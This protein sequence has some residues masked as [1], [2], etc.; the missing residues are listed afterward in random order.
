MAEP[1]TDAAAIRIALFGQPRV[2]SNDGTHEYLLPRKTL[3]VLAY[4]IL[5]R[6]RAP[7]R[8]TIAFAL[9]PDDDEETAR[10]ALRRNLSYLLQ[11]LPDGRRF[12]D[13][14][15]ERIAWKLDA[16]AHVDV[17]AFEQA[18]GEGRDADAIAEYAGGLLPTI[19]DEWTTPDRERLRDA[20]HNALSRTIAL[21]RSRRN[22]DAATATARRLLDDDPWREDIVRQLMAVRYE[23][24]DRAGALSAFERFAALLRSEM[25]TEPMPETFALRDTVLR[26][27]R[28]PT[29]EPPR[30][31]RA[32]PAA[33][34]PGLPFVGRDAAMKRAHAAWQTAADGRAGLLFVSG[35]AGVGKS[36]FTTELVRL[37]ER[38]GGF[39]AR[40]YTSAGGEQQPYEAFIE[41]LHGT[42]SLLEQQAG[43]VL[44]DD[45]AARL[46][47][48][49]SVRHRL[50]ELSRARP[51]VLVLEDL[52][53]A[54]ASTIEL[55]DFVA[56]RLERTPVLIVATARS[57]ELARAHPLRPVRRELLRHGPAT[58][59]ALD[60]LGID[61]ATRAARAA[62]PETVDE[63][64]LQRVISWVD[65]V[66]LLLAE[67]VRDLAAGRTSTA[68][69]MTTLVAE[70][71]ER[72]SSSAE[73]A[74]IFGALL[75][76]RFDLGTLVAAT[77]WRDDQ[78]LD[79]L[80]E[81]IE[82]GFVRAAPH[83]PDLAF[84]FTHDLVRVA[85]MARISESDL[86]RTH[87]LIARAIRA[88]DPESG[89]RARQIARHFAAAG[90]PVRAAEH[91][92]NA[93]R[94]ALHVFANEDARE[95]AAAA[96]ALCDENE[97]AQRA[98]RY[99]L[100]DLREQSLARIGAT[101]QRRADAELLVTLAAG[102]EE[103][104][105]ALG[106]L[107]EAHATDAAGRREA[108][109]RLAAF[110]GTS[111]LAARTHAAAAARHAYLEGEYA[112][113]REAALRA[114]EAFELAG[115]PRAALK[116]RFVGITCLTRIGSFTQ[117][118]AEVE[119]LRPIV[120]ASDDD[121]LR[122]EFHLIAS[123]ALGETRRE[124]ALEDAR[125]SLALALRIGDRYGE[126][127]ARHNVAVIAGKLR[128]Y[129]EALDGHER[130]LAAYRDVGDAP[131]V[132]DTLLNIAGVRIWCGDY[133]RPQQL[134]DEVGVEEEATPWLALRCQ[135][136]RGALAERTERTADAER[137]LIDAH[138]R[139]E[140]LGTALYRARSEFELAK[141]LASHGRPDAAAGYVRSALETY[142]TMG[143]PDLEIEALALGAR[144]LAS[145]GDASGA[146]ER[147]ERAAARCKEKRLQSYSEIAWNLAA[148]Y[149]L[150]G[151]E[152]AA[153]AYARDAAAAAVDDALRMPADLAETYLQL[154]W[155]QQT[156]AYLSGRAVPLRFE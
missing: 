101:E 76:E 34:E 87:G 104:A 96:L 149:A 74:L 59:I 54:G 128:L 22:Y 42:P 67:A 50:S 103:T 37:A 72:L 109:Q 11:T 140:E 89:P 116:A 156:V 71:F 12:I 13:A 48:F 151:D 29:S 25:Q 152:P 3:N 92:R 146:C 14:D 16:P 39:I 155:H 36:R 90:E 119:V 121:V 108:L 129:E 51:V 23:G 106:R 69:S 31:V 6:R 82:C 77:A 115:D 66:P 7:T 53:W 41:A 139:A 127:R 30:S 28:L 134:L 10:G 111:D 154:P 49:D 136:I 62:L 61:D 94:Y 131:G 113:A 26:S 98:L 73:T 84:E 114:A 60:R 35:E 68:S 19:Y 2:L 18:V 64:A 105:V 148:A 100:V 122:C 8:D 93:A 24:G 20:F 57:D 78:I 5:N 117:G 91:L 40:G 4:L 75:G 135:F 86:T 142:A 138:R 21:D 17:L 80:G 112:F 52:H 33:A 132:R 46:R 43:T 125:R 120:A 81:S 97:P 44:T 126:A 79:A 55:L 32:E 102:E 95:A 124:A 70:R 110:A 15:T 150:I 38:E 145:L 153:Q 83:S 133:E 27:A 9:F 118:E 63:V 88:Q 65:G 130:A 85:A 137:D 45:R 99:D 143:Q 123:A 147:A 107:F 141:L 58:E 47:F 144:L 56:R 1:A